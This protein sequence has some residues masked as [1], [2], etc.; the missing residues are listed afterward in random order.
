MREI[1][2][3]QGLVAVVDDSDFDVLDQFN[4]HAARRART[5]YAARHKGRNK[6]VLMHAEI[7][8]TPSGFDTDHI[9]GNGLNNVRSNLR[10]TTVTQNRYNQ[11]RKRRTATSRFRG[12]S[13][14]KKLGRW[15]AQIRLHGQ[16]TYLGLFDDEVEA[17]RVYDAAGLARDPEHFTPNFPRA[18][19]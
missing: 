2:L 5:V 16:Q 7:M 12:V 11:I 18:E 13:W 14:N 19:K 4:W 8:Q 17:A 6:I 1:A 3:T 9:D 10:V 15:V